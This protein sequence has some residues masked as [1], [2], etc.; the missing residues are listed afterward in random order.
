MYIMCVMLVQRFEPQGRRFT[1]FHYYYY[2]YYRQAGRQSGRQSGR[3]TDRQTD[4]QAD[5]QTDRGRGPSEPARE[6][7]S[8]PDVKLF[9]FFFLGFPVLILALSN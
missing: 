4:R 1:N 9:S 2:Y 5:R 8:V 6:V 7:V 3:Q